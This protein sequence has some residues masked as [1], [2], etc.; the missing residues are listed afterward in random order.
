M[1][2]LSPPDTHDTQSPSHRPI[3]LLVLDID[4]T[5][6]NSHHEIAAGTVEMN[7]TCKIRETG[8]PQWQSELKTRIK[9][10]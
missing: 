4:G 9:L 8:K 5:V 7:V 6:S 3:R 1:T 2:G 10:P